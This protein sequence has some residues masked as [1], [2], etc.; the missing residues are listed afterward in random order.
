MFNGQ[1][2]RKR[3]EREKILALLIDQQMYAGFSKH[4]IMNSRRKIHICHYGQT[5]RLKV[6]C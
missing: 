5:E 1:E 3:K 6:N 4:S 2:K